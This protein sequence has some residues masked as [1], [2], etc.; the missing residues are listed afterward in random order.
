MLRLSRIGHRPASSCCLQRFPIDRGGALRLALSPVVSFSRSS[1]RS[2]A[3]PAGFGANGASSARASP[4]Q[5]PIMFRVCR[6][7]RG[8]P[9]ASAPQRSPLGLGVRV[10]AARWSTLFGN[11]HE[12]IIPRRSARTGSTRLSEWLRSGPLPG[13]LPLVVLLVV[14]ETA[15]KRPDSPFFPAPSFLVGRRCF[16]RGQGDTILPAVADTVPDIRIRSLAAADH[17]RR[18]RS[19]LSVGASK[20]GWTRPLVRRSSL[21]ALCRLQQSFRWPHSC[22]DS[23]ETMKVGRRRSCQPSGPSCSTRVALCEGLNP[24][25][26]E[27]ARSLRL[28]KTRTL[29]GVPAAL[30]GRHR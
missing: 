23:D 14:W 2:S 28:S 4:L 8:T 17:S 18:P 5:P 11:P 22:L 7:P 27:T 25:L 10:A 3:N 16:R 15:R 1:P 29:F 24:T 13:L 9:G 12:G 19:A 6:R 26:L 30:R 21:R 20:R